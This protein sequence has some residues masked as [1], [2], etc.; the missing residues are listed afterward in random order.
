MSGA[1]NIMESRFDE[2]EF[3]VPPSRTSRIV[4]ECPEFYGTLEIEKLEWLSPQGQEWLQLD[5]RARDSILHPSSN[6]TLSKLYGKQPNEGSRLLVQVHDIK[7]MSARFMT[8]SHPLS[9]II[10]SRDRMYNVLSLDVGTFQ[11]SQNFLARY[12]LWALIDHIIRT[13]PAKTPVEERTIHWLVNSCLLYFKNHNSHHDPSSFNV[14][15]DAERTR[16]KQRFL[17][18]IPRAELI[19]IF[20]AHADWL[21]AQ[22]LA[23]PSAHTKLNLVKWI[24]F[25]KRVSRARHQAKRRNISWGLPYGGTASE[26]LDLSRF[27]EDSQFWDNKLR[28]AQKPKPKSKRVRKLTPPLENKSVAHKRRQPE[29]IY[30]SDFSEASTSGYSDA[31]DEDS[32]FE[33]FDV[34]ILHSQPPILPVGRFE[35]QCPDCNYTIDLLNLSKENLEVLPHDVAQRLQEMS[36]K[37]VRDGDIQTSFF[38]MVRGHHCTVQQVP[39]QMPQRKKKKIGV[40]LEDQDIDGWSMQG[41]ERL[42]RR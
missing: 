18:H 2:T 17:R 40:K 32:T 16:S 42:R 41:S 27:G 34:H 8:D 28:N 1:F 5:L 26:D 37:S 14:S 19:G 25:C 15:N 6:L 4:N 20:A 13:D 3:I 29:F 22:Q 38:T 39:R 35:W 36:W 7:N 31:T 21:L 10:H 24:S 12:R 33:D 23:A 30:D 9:L 11:A